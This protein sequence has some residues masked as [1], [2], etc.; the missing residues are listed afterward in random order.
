[1]TNVIQLERVHKQ[2]LDYQCSKCG[3]ERGCD[4]NAPAIK[5]AAA[6]LAANPQKSDRAIAAEIGISQPTVSKARK[7]S[8]DNQLSP[9]THVGRD[10]KSYSA[11]TKRT[12][13]S[14]APKS[15]QNSLTKKL[16]VYKR[17]LT[18][19]EAEKKRLQQLV[20]ENEQELH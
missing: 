5:K 15:Q 10:G 17:R 8:G 7:Q 9:D 19:L 2:A 4:C 6:A 18:K 11:K 14:P 1:M 16:A 20:R 3:A 13:S 12:R